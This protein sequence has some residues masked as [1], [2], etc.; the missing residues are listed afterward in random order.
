[1]D[2]V[3]FVTLTVPLALPLEL[4][5][6]IDRHARSVQMSIPELLSNMLIDACEEREQ[7][8]H[9]QAAAEELLRSPLLTAQSAA[10]HLTFESNGRKLP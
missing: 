5:N 4:V 1:M 2:K 3:N 9:G 8:E 10:E 6:E 7:E